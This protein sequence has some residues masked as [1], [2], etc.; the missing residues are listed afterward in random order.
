[1]SLS[2]CIMRLC[3]GVCVRLR[4]V[5]VQVLQ[6]LPRRSA[7]LELLPGTQEGLT[8]FDWCRPLT[9]RLKL[10]GADRW[11]Q[12]FTLQPPP[13]EALQ[14]A[15]AASAGAPHRAA[16]KGDVETAAAVAQDVCGSSSMQQQHQHAAAAAAGQ[17]RRGAAAESSLPFAP[18]AGIGTSRRGSMLSNSSGSAAA[19][20]PEE[21]DTAA[22]FSDGS[23]A[24]AGAKASGRLGKTVWCV[25]YLVSCPQHEQQQQQQEI[26][27]EASF[28]GSC[29]CVSCFC[30]FWLLNLTKHSLE[31]R[32]TLPPSA[33][34]SLHVLPI[35]LPPC[36]S[37][38]AG[39]AA[40]EA[41][42]IGEGDPEEGLLSP[43]D[44]WESLPALTCLCHASFSLRLGGTRRFTQEI[45]LRTSAAAASPFA[46]AATAQFAA[47]AAAE[48]TASQ[49]PEVVRL[50]QGVEILTQISKLCGAFGEATL[51]VFKPKLVLQTGIHA[52]L[53]MYIHIY[54]CMYVYVC[55]FLPIFLFLEVSISVTL[56]ASSVLLCLLLQLPV[57]PSHAVAVSSLF[58]LSLSR[59]AASLCQIL[60]V[61]LCS[62]V[63]YYLSH[64]WPSLSVSVRLCV[65]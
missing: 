24:A 21:A 40:A 54:I 49:P 2:S 3:V 43:K 55:M 56:C 64:S 41:A 60:P 16:S 35:H 61:P 65:S 33:G 30:P 48:S 13:A 14:A 62:P 51:I 15:A 27:I 32:P 7:S 23:T 57:S 10:Q 25:S 6:E 46:A 31:Y 63:C 45:L 20:D 1:M 37:I 39:G 4:Q 58:C 26:R 9:I 17:A 44:D 8:L 36:S 18:A 38:A 47:P 29:L 50:A 12:P 11:S 34:D 42:G 59:L 5:G 19:A 22:G 52:C 53:Y 28:D